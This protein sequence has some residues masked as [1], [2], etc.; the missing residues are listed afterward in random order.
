MLLLK[1]D[2]KHPQYSQESFPKRS[3]LLMSESSTTS[4]IPTTTASAITLADRAHQSTMISNW[5]PQNLK[6]YED[7]PGFTSD[8]FYLFF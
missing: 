8:L 7:S 6:T 2:L 5:Q 3:R 1:T 4:V